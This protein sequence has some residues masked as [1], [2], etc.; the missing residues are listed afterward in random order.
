MEDW[1]LAALSF[2]AIG[3]GLSWVAYFAWDLYTSVPPGSQSP[4]I[5][6]PKKDNRREKRPAA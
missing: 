2:A 4:P 6:K 3:G 5:A 1:G